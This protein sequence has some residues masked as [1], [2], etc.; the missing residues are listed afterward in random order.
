VT[1]IVVTVGIPVEQIGVVIGKM[2]EFIELEEGEFD[3]DRIT[4]EELEITQKI[5]VEKI[6]EELEKTQPLIIGEE[7]E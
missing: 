7:H 3:F 5:D 4:P 2:D 1:G 6:N